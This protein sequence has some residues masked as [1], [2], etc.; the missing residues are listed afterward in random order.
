VAPSP[1]SSSFRLPSLFLFHYQKRKKKRQRRG[2]FEI[3][4]WERKGTGFL[5]RGIKDSFIIVDPVPLMEALE[6]LRKTVF[7]CCA[8]ADS[9][10]NHVTLAYFQR[11]P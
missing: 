6:I 4:K 9:A 7:N 3:K 10:I 11:R 2:G 5:G 1:K 8:Q